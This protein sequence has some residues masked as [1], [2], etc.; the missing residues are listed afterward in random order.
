MTFLRENIPAFDWFLGLM[1]LNATSVLIFLSVQ[2]EESLLFLPIL[3]LPLAFFAAIG[4]AFGSNK[5]RIGAGFWY[6]FFFGPIGWLVIAIG[7]NKTDRRTLTEKLCD[8]KTAYDSGVINAQEFERYKL[9]LLS[10][11]STSSGDL[12]T[13]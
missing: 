13:P 5:G 8:L 9:K 6:G 11:E 1:G 10:V 2:N 7:P 3:T 12:K 4:A